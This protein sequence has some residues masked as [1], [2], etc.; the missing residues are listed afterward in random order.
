MLL[1]LEGQF[2]SGG[3]QHPEQ[4]LPSLLSCPGKYTPGLPAG[5]PG[6]AE[7]ASK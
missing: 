5:G 3:S 4:H 2:I 6:K 1:L 7:K